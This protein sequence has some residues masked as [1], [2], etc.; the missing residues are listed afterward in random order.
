MV[1]VTLALNDVPLG[2]YEVRRVTNAGRD[3]LGAEELSQ[4]QVSKIVR[5]DDVV[6]LTVVGFVVHRYG[7]G[8]ARLAARALTLAAQYEDIM[9]RKG[10]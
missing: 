8:A 1:R 4:Y 10:E 2:D 5:D 7:D 3:D 9:T 6:K